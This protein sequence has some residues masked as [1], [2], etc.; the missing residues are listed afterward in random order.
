MA[1]T[2]DV[3]FAR[4]SLEHARLEEGREIAGAVRLSRVVGVLGEAEVGKTETIRGALRRAGAERPVICLDLD[5]AAG[6]G[7]LAF[8]LLH[9]IASTELGMG[10]S[11]LKAG[12]L[13][14]K[15]L[16]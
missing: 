3:K 15:S 6:E 12:A 10:L 8:R 7:H 2:E 13:V 16:E 1:L 9:Q 14:P 4:W 5:C 11:I